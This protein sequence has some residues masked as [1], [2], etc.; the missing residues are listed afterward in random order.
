VLPIT[1]GAEQRVRQ[2]SRAALAFAVAG[3]AAFFGAYV[4]LAWARLGV[5]LLV[6]AG[7]FLVAG[8]ASSPRARRDADRGTVELR[9]VHPAFVQAVEASWSTPPPPAS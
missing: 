7:G 2:L 4:D 6:I 1:V 3:V 9:N 5:A 8:Y